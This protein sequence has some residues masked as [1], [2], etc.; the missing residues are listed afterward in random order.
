MALFLLAASARC[1]RPTT[2]VLAAP[3]DQHL[4][5]GRA[6]WFFPHQETT[7]LTPFPE[8][9]PLGVFLSLLITTLDCDLQLLSAPVI[10]TFC[11]L[12]N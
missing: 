3:R 10:F 4:A 12:L 11:D 1:V 2:L 7:F 8:T 9:G 5:G 6:W